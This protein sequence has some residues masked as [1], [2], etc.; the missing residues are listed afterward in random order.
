MISNLK[1]DIEFRREKA[2]ELS[3]QVQRHLAAGGKLTIGDSPAINPDP[4][5]R[6]E[7]ID[8]ETILKRRKP[9]ITAAERKALRK[10]AE[11]L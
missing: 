3:S 9:P 5:K 11:A 1:S 4:A 10:L 7:K 6:S 8:P 2:L